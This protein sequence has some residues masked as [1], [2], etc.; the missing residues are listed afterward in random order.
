MDIPSAFTTSLTSLP[1]RSMTPDMLVASQPSTPGPSPLDS[2]YVSQSRTPNKLSTPSETFDFGGSY[3]LDRTTGDLLEK[4]VRDESDECPR[5][6]FLAP[7]QALLSQASISL[8]AS[9]SSARPCNVRANSTKASSVRQ[10]HIARGSLPS[11][12]YSKTIPRTTPRPSSESRSSYLASGPSASSVRAPDRF[13]HPRDS[14]CAA[15][16][17]SEKFR[18][19]KAST[20]LNPVEKILRRGMISADAFYATQTHPNPIPTFADERQNFLHVAGQPTQTRAGTTLD[21]GNMGD[22]PGMEFRRRLTRGSVW[23]ISTIP[24]TT[25]AIDNGNGTLTQSGTSSVPFITSTFTEEGPRYSASYCDKHPSRLA[26]ALD[27][28]RASRLMQC[29]V[30]KGVFKL[31][32]HDNLIVPTTKR[33]LLPKS[34]KTSWNGTI[35]VNDG[36]EKKPAKIP[37]KTAWDRSPIRILSAPKFRDDFYCSLLAYSP[38]TDTV[39]VG[40]ADLLYT[41]SEVGGAAHLNGSDSTRVWLTSLAFSSVEGGKCILA[42]G[43]SNGT[44]GLMAISEA[45]NTRMVVQETS[46]ISCLSWRP[47]CTMRP[48]QN[49]NKENVLVS[50]EDLLVG[51]DAGIVLYYVIEWPDTSE[52]DED[53]WQGDITLVSRINVHDQQVCGLAWA[54]NGESFA[55]GGNDNNCCFFY[56]NNVLPPSYHK[57]GHEGVS[58]NLPFK[59]HYSGIADSR[60]TVQLSNGSEVRKRANNKEYEHRGPGRTESWRWEHGAAVKAIAFCPWQE[61]LVATGGGS[62]D[63]CVHFFHT[64]S[65][66]PLATIFVSSQVTSLIWST[67]RREIAVTFGFA[68]PGHDIRIAVYSWP[69]CKQV[70]AITWE[71]KHRALY[72]IS[73]S[74][75]RRWGSQ[76]S[77]IK[78][79]KMKEGCIAVA[80]SDGSIKFYELWPD[81]GKPIIGGV[82]MLGG[83]DILEDLEGIQKEGDIIR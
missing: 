76:Q 58:N 40:L 39:A 57:G 63:R 32:S 33:K 54:P 26:A 72:G 25:G 45:N 5:S 12:F 11:T 73:C 60:L 19:T 10:L 52:I 44:F 29:N 16:P 24:P 43:R 53:N 69:E 78:N 41:W 9:A 18:M 42:F 49:P 14:E 51:T 30:D 59:S 56:V 7:H 79:K 15:F 35:W 68:H 47:T 46:A 3:T 64:T 61:G 23:S 31:Q 62:N 28:D 20:D 74:Q 17:I 8:K 55:T 6:A 37:E 21:T 80:S 4:L 36:L 82:G 75:G 77:I 83:S 50:T 71:G 34:Q 1:I 70:A 27:F 67:T 81:D 65:G 48:S 13:V 22:D 2:G 66:T 38:T